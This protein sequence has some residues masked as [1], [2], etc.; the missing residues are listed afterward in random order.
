M[1]VMS[2]SNYHKRTGT[3][4]YVAPEVLRREYTQA[5]DIWSIGMY[6]IEFYFIFLCLMKDLSDETKRPH[7]NS[8]RLFL[9]RALLA[10]SL[11]VSSHLP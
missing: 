9:Q 8:L 2:T 11:F 10:V 1:A 4:Y 3:P 7:S 6:S 5:A